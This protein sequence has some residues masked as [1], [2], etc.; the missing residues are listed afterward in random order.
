MSLEFK[1]RAWLW[2]I[3]IIIVLGGMVFTYYNIQS[4]K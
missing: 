1:V 4:F 3:L 2:I